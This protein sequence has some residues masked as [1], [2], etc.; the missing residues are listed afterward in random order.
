[1]L[2]RHHGVADGYAETDLGYTAQTWAMILDRLA[3]Y[4]VSGTA[5]P[6]FPASG[7]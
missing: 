4:A 7:E 1:V 3:A 2:F 5:Q 6:Y